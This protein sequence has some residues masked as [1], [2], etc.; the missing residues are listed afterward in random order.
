LAVQPKHSADGGA[1][2]QEHG[3]ADQQGT[4]VFLEPMKLML[5]S[6]QQMGFIDLKSFGGNFDAVTH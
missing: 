4:P 3:E 1:R 5:Q 2:K 6:T